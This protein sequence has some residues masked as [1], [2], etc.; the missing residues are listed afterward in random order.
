MMHP[1]MELASGAQREHEVEALRQH[2]ADR[3]LNPESFDFYLDPFR[4]GM[5]PHSGWAVGGD[6]LV[7]TMLG[8]DNIREAVMFPRD[9]NRLSP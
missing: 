6:R 9:R 5:P 1:E 8:L 7:Q 4:F 3:G 2:I